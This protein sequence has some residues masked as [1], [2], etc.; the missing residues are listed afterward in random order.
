MGQKLAEQKEMKAESKD[1]RV[2]PQIS[3]Q[4]GYIPHLTARTCYQP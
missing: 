1:V 3:L 2:Q 4:Q